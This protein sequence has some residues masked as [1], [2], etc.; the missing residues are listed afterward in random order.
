MREYVSETWGWIDDLQRA[1]FDE[2]NIIEFD[3][4][5]VGSIS[6]RRQVGELFLASIEIAP[7]F[8]KRGIGTQLLLKLLGEAD[9]VKKPVRLRVLKVNPARRLYARLGFEVLQED[10]THYTMERTPAA[11]HFEP[12]PA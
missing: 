2:L 6:V 1:R 3:Q 11:W 10:E 4:V 12:P 7:D 8:Q 5:P 9:R